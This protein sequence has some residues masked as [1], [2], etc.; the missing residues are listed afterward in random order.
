MH[1]RKGMLV[2]VISGNDRGKEGRVLRV[3]PKT[4]RVIVEGVNFIK[5]ATRPTQ[6]NPGGGFIEKEAAVNASNV[7]LLVG[8]QTTRIGYKKLED[9]SK[10]RI[11]TK[12]G[13]EIES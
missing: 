1:I 5:R 6:T 11:A 13:E 7:M 3:Y 2:R 12:T 9:G 8:G 4:G 10:V